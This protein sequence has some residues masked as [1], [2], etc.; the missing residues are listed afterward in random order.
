[1]HPAAEIELTLIPGADDPPVRDTDYQ[2]E[3]REFKKSLDT[4]GLEVSA[5]FEVPVSTGTDSLA[6]I[7]PTYL[8]EFII[9]GLVPAV[10]A[11]V[12]ADWLRKRGREVG[13]KVKVHLKRGEIKAVVVAQTAEDVV[14]VLTPVMAKSKGARSKRKRPKR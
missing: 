1:M 6:F 4:L 10:A 2:A 5:A 12:I 14:K 3:L 13:M 7:F 8:G 11:N 9:K